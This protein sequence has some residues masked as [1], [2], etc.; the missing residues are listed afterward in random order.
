[1]KRTTAVCMI[2]LAVLL[3]FASFAIAGDIMIDKKIKSVTFKKDKN[4]NEYARIIVTEPRELNGVHY[5]KDVVVMAFGDTVAKAKTLKQGTNLKG[6]ATAQ[7][8]R[9]NVTYHLLE[10]SK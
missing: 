1:M 6:V 5:V 3:A 2:A 8:Y 4:G 9:G 10:I 7:E